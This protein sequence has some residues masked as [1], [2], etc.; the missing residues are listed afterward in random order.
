MGQLGFFAIVSQASIPQGSL[1]IDRNSPSQPALEV[2]QFSED[3]FIDLP[4]TDRGILGADSAMNKQ[5]IVNLLGYE[6]TTAR[7]HD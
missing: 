1:A 4:D 3:S 5:G 2:F 6:S 7:K